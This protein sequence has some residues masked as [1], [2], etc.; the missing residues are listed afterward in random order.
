M[1]FTDILKQHVFENNKMKEKQ[2]IL[3]IEMDNVTIVEFTVISNLHVLENKKTKFKEEWTETVD[4]IGDEYKLNY[5]IL[6]IQKL[7]TKYK[8]IILI[9][10]LKLI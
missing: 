2:V 3:Y 5:C 9:N 7:N 4:I 10:K 8:Y 1:E 6:N